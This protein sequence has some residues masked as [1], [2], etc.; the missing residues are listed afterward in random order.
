MIDNIEDRYKNL[1]DGIMHLNDHAHVWVIHQSHVYQSPAMYYL[2]QDDFYNM[3][4]E[5]ETNLNP[6]ELLDELKKIEIIA[7]RNPNR[8]K[9]MPRTLDMDILAIGNMLIR[10]DLLNI[11]H[12]KITERRFVL[13]P[14]NDIAPDFQVPIIDKNIQ[15]L[16]Q[17]TEDVSRTQMLL[18]LNK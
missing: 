12:P 13:K 1:K 7:G 18:I 5:I 8:K 16:L 9:N 10:S 11:P 4:I 3:V 17:I 6:L 14:W 2:D 15:E